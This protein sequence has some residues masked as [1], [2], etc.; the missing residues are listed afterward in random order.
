MVMGLR[1]LFLGGGAVVRSC[2]LPK[3]GLLYLRRWASRMAC[4]P[5]RRLGSCGATGREW[6]S[7]DHR[8]GRPASASVSMVSKLSRLLVRL[9]LAFVRIRSCASREHTN[10]SYS[11]AAHSSRAA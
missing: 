10:N 8:T 1:F 7:G 5:F 6:S 2:A 9:S 11:A 3:A 4:C